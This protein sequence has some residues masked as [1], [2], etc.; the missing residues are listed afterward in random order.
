MFT[1]E[2]KEE[3]RTKADGR[4]KHNAASATGRYHAWIFLDGV[5]V[6]EVNANEDRAIIERR[7]KAIVGALN[8][9]QSSHD[10]EEWHRE[11]MARIDQQSTR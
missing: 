3:T 6:V 9:E 7:A 4:K 5:I 11:Q 1:F 8:K 2:V 10:L